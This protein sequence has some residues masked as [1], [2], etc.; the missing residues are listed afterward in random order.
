MPTVQRAQE[1][2]QGAP[3]LAVGRFIPAAPGP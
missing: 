1:L 3:I 2:S